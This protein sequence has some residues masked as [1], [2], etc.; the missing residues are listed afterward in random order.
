MIIMKNHENLRI[1]QENQHKF[2]N[3]RIPLENHENPGNGRIQRANYE[4]QKKIWSSM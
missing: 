3:C 4:N 2:R 1:R